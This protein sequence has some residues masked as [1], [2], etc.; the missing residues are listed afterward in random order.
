MLGRLPINLHYW[1]YFISLVNIIEMS[2]RRK[3]LHDFIH[4]LNCG[5]GSNVIMFIGRSPF[6]NMLS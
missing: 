6:G 4:E 5:G 3:W 1:T 2:L